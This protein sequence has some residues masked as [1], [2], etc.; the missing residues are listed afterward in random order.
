MNPIGSVPS[1]PSHAASRHLGL[2]ASCRDVPMLTLPS[3]YGSVYVIMFCVS[4]PR[5]GICIIL[6]VLGNSMTSDMSD[7]M[8]EYTRSMVPQEHLCGLQHNFPSAKR[9]LDYMLLAVAADTGR[10]NTTS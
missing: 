6:Q 3:G 8:T 9:S 7:S 1:Y 5:G 10:H 4:P 2:D